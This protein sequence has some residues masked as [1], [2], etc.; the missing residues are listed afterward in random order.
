MTEESFQQ[1]RKVMQKA[2]HLRGRITAAK[3]LVGKWIRIL[4]EHKANG[5]DTDKTQAVVDTQMAKLESVRAKFDAM[6][7]PDHN[8]VVVKPK[9]VQCENCGNLT[10]EGDTYCKNCL[11]H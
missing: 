10:P 8:I 3:Q 5:R 11:T 9:M 4:E 7:F 1:A 2:N 6:K